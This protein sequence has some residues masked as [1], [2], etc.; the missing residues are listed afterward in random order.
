MRLIWATWGSPATCLICLAVAFELSIILPVGTP[1]LWGKPVMIYT[2]FIYHFRH[3]IL[4]FYKKPKDVSMKYLGSFRWVSGKIDLNLYS[5]IP[6]I[7]T[8]CTFSEVC[9]EIKVGPYFICLG[10]A[11]LFKLIPNCIQ[12]KV[13]F[14]QALGHILVHA[15]VPTPSYYLLALL[16]FWECCK[17]ALKYFLTF[18][19]PFPESKV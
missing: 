12:A 18:K 10:L 1:C 8:S 11:K 2:A 4:I 15:K 6:L 17:L 9:Q 14:R 3:K 13:F 5:V 19:P 16:A 7:Y